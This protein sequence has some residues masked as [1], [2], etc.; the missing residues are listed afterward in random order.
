MKTLN[1]V[2]VGYSEGGRAAVFKLVQDGD[3][4]M[5]RFDRD[6]RHDADAIGVYTTDG[7]IIAYAPRGNRKLIE[8]VRSRTQIMGTILSKIADPKGRNHAMKVNVDL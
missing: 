8:A 7:R 5:L 2:G 6:N 1:L 3:R 4:V